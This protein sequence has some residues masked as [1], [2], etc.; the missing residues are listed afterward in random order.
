MHDCRR[1]G[2]N[3]GDDGHE[4][5]VRELGTDF[6]LMS[7]FADKRRFPRE[8]PWDDV[9][10]NLLEQF[11]ALMCKRPQWNREECFAWVSGL[12]CLLLIFC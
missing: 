12:V 5:L 4:Y 3:T 8:V 7:F 1:G 11:L 10:R 2:A 9:S 6:Y